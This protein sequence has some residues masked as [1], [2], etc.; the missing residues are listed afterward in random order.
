MIHS[1]QQAENAKLRK[2]NEML[3]QENREL[4]SPKISALESQLE[5]ERE[6]HEVLEMLRA[7]L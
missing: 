4:F 2:E 5:D 7:H 1:L 6:K 3:R